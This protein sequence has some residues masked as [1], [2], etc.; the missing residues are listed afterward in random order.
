MIEAGGKNGVSDQ[1]YSGGGHSGSWTTLVVKR[2]LHKMIG[3]GDWGEV[4]GFACFAVKQDVPQAFE[5][6]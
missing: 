3:N 5:Q 1:E 4:V 2:C 6:S